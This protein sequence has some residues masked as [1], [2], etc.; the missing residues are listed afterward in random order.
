VP[1]LI[2][3]DEA[4]Y[5]SIVKRWRPGLLRLAEA[6]TGSPASAEDVVQ[7]TWVSVLKSL[8]TFE[9]RSSLRTW[10]H[11]LCVHTA[12]ARTRQDGRAPLPI[13]SS[14]GWPDPPACWTEETPEAL[15][16]RREVMECIERAVE[17]LPPRQRAVITLRDVHGFSSQE[18]REI[19]GVSEVNQRVLLH[20]ARSQVRCEYERFHREAA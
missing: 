10:V 5:A 17:G 18:A 9:G 13:E 8:L 20:R 1:R 3:G 6:I 12:L 4:L 14:G 11:R 16:V 15:A 7:E 2:A 19:L